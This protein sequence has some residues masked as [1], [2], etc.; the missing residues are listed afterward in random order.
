M[1]SINNAENDRN[2]EVRKP[3]KES[4]QQKRLSDEEIAE[5]LREAI[6]AGIRAREAETERRLSSCP[7]YGWEDICGWTWLEVDTEIARR[8]IRLGMQ[9][10]RVSIQMIPSGI[11]L[12]KSRLYLDEVSYFPKFLASLEG[13]KASAEV[14]R[15]RGIQAEERGEPD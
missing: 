3:S 13:L 9:G 8:I 15:S 4:P 11:C 1:H 12:R 10:V 5:A 7:I 6:T 2:R 14:L